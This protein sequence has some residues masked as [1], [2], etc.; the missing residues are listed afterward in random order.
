MKILVLII[1]FVG[2]DDLVLSDCLS[3]KLFLDV[4]FWMSNMEL[5]IYGSL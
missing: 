2:I 1:N 5:G 4:W 3:G